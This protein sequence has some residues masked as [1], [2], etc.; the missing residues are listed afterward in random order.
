MKSDF[1]VRPIGYED[2]KSIIV[3]HHYLGQIYDEHDGWVRAYKYFGLFEKGTLMGAIQYTAYCHEI[4]GVPILQEYYGCDEQDFTHFYEISRLAVAPTKEY[5]I[6]SWFVSRTMKMCNAEYICTSTDARLHEG[7]IY[8]ACNMQFH[9]TLTKRA[10]CYMDVP[11]NVF[12]KI[13]RKDIKQTW[14][15]H[16][17]P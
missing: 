14:E 10:A 3:K 16:P 5:N 15:V 7:V 17:W 11:F 9:G 6:T 4:N 8:A 13:Y 1:E 2:A 12:S